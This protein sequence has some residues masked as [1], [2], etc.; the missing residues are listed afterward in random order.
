VLRGPGPAGTAPEPRERQH[1]RHPEHDQRHPPPQRARFG[2]LGSQRQHA[3]LKRGAQDV[4][5]GVEPPDVPGALR[6]VGYRLGHASHEAHVQEGGQALAR[7]YLAEESPERR[8]ASEYV[9][10]LGEQAL[11]RVADI[12]VRSFF[13]IVAAAI[14]I[15]FVR[16]V[17][18]ILFC[19]EANAHVT[20]T[21]M[22]VG[23]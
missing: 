21:R 10:R 13:L 16:R 20:Y 18:S 23:F 7:E 2:V 15:V 1:G 9:A 4:D 22:Q 12:I 11:L 8:H 14:A 6:V 19:A 3:E 5:A 17:E